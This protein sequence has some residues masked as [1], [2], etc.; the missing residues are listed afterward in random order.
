MYVPSLRRLGSFTVTSWLPDSFSICKRITPDT[1]V[2]YA[3]GYLFSDPDRG[4]T[5][6]G[7]L[8]IPFGLQEFPPHF[9]ESR[10]LFTYTDSS[11]GTKPRPHGGHVVMRCNG[12]ILWSAKTLKVVTD[13]TA[14]AETAEASR[15]T[16][17][18]VFLRM[19]LDGNGRP[20]VCG[21]PYCHPRRQ[22][23]H[24]RARHQGR[25]L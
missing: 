24:G 7:P 5:Y 12:A 18:T 14:H 4:I 3:M 11:W 22:L 10:G 20:M 15:A 21:R 13:S 17:A 25:G 16:K 19:V 23:G 2:E 6:G 9:N 8:K 1:P